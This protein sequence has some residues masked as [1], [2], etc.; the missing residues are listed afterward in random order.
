MA[1]KLT[2]ETEQPTFN[3]NEEV[4]FNSEPS[5]NVKDSWN[6]I[7]L[8]LASK[9]GYTIYHGRK[10]VLYVFIQEKINGKTVDTVKS[11]IVSKNELLQLENESREFSAE[12][13]AMLIAREKE[14][15]A[16]TPIKDTTKDNSK[17]KKKDEVK[18]TGKA[19]TEVLKKGLNSI[20]KKDPIPYNNSE[21]DIPEPDDDGLQDSISDDAYLSRLDRYAED[22][23]KLYE[24]DDQDRSNKKV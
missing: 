22:Y 4:N 10:L 11:F 1:N 2:T 7:T 12:I 13:E 21:D 24:K 15:I 16:A 5:K 3:F 6:Q 19:L 23:A 14:H 8:S 20:K 9:G 18:K 17:D